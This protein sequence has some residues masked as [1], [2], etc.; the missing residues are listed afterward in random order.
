MAWLDVPKKMA[1]FLRLGIWAAR[2]ETKKD[3]L[4]PRLLAW[5][6][7]AAVGAGVMEGLAAKPEGRVTERL[8]KLVRMQVSLAVAC[9]FCI[10]M[11]SFECEQLGITL[12]EVQAM[13]GITPLEAV[14]SFSIA[15]RLALR[16]VW[17][18]SQTPLQVSQAQMETLKAH[19]NERELVLLV[20][21]A[22]QVNYWARLIQ[23]LGVPP[24][25]FSP[26]CSWV[27]GPPT[28]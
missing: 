23:S 2:R 20:S 12:E 17:G 22:A 13:Q 14:N 6:P 18:V 19:F 8:L 24:A 27:K 26:Q 3:L 28:G 11:N 1:W 9:P 15:E 16:Y 4:P 25:G 5:Y 7:R 21:T 10:D